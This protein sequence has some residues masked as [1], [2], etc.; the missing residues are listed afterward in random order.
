MSEQISISVVIPTYNRSDLLLKAVKSVL[1]QTFQVKEILICDDGS[2][3]DSKA[4]LAALM[5]PAIKWIDCG[6]N[7]G[8]AIP[9]NIGIK[10]SSGNWIAFLD[11]D[12]E[13]VN[14]KLEEQV[15]CIKRRNCLA[16]SSNAT[17]VIDQ[18]EK[19]PYLKYSSGMIGFWNLF[20][21]N[22][23]ILSTLLISKN[24]LSR[25]HFFPVDPRLNAIE[26]YTLLFKITIFSEITFIDKQLVFYSD[27]PSVS[28]RAIIQQ[29]FYEQ[30][31]LATTELLKWTKKN[32]ISLNIL[33]KS[34]IVLFNSRAVKFKYY[35]IN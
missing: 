29:S 20:W 30:R 31:Y 25:A 2:T 5:I 35:L 34:L 3:D 1:A 23:V 4:K 6:R 12:D 8:P 19:G 15:S 7:G 13:W 11:S 14:T 17:S 28:H 9:R 18:V 32:Y 16:V 21:R 24:L 10:H 27:M 26:D 22:P 33:Q